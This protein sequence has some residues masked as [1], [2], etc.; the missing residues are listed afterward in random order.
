MRLVG[1][2]HCMWVLSL[3]SPLTLVL[4]IGYIIWTRQDLNFDGYVWKT[5]FMGKR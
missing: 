1:D 4:G 5:R 3:A 2:L